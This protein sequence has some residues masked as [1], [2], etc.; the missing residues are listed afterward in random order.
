[1]KTIYVVDTKLLM[2][3]E[4]HRGNATSD[5]FQNLALELAQFGKGKMYFAYDAPEGS[6][7][8]KALFPEYKANRDNKEEKMTK[9]EKRLFKEFKLEYVRYKNV[10]NK[11]GNVLYLA[12]WEADDHAN[13]ICQKFAGRTDVQIIMVSSD[14]DWSMN[15]TH[16]NIKLFHWGR[17]LLIV[18]QEQ[19]KDVFNLYSNEA[20]DAQAFAGIAKEN[21][22]GI[23]NFGPTRFLECVTQD[24]TR[25]QK[26]KSVQ[27]ILDQ[28]TTKTQIAKN[29]GKWSTKIPDR[30]ESLTEMYN[31]NYELLRPVVMSD[32]DT[33]E[34][35]SFI[36]QFTAPKPDSSVHGVVGAF[37]ELNQVYLPDFNIIEFFN[38]TL[39][40]QI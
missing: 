10:L 28:R 23:K 31:F 35:N 18:N 4:Y 32:L 19:V 20:L 2:Y 17:K 3:T 16:D 13:L 8:R 11:F 1:M 33:G 37:A 40:E 14:R 29:V 34:R 21:V 9:I 25:E 5:M 26:L 38:L 24:M 39:P 22:D 36:R 27:L 7:R 15:M 12:G 30:Y 6:K